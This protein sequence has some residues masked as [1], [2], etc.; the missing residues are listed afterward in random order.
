MI[1]FLFSGL[2]CLAL[3]IIGGL[4][5]LWSFDAGSSTT[6]GL[7]AMFPVLGLVAVAVVSFIAGKYLWKRS[8]VTPRL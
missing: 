8:G 4:V 2:S 3:L 5:L 1:A 6:F 7:S